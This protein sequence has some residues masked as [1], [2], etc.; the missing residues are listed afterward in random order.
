M[1]LP[2]VEASYCV[3]QILDVLQ[4]GSKAYPLGDFTT[5]LFIIVAFD[6]DK[7]LARLSYISDGV[8]PVHTRTRTAPRA[9]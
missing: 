9:T 5:S 7:T 6:T 3:A 4:D 1:P 2:Q 8:R